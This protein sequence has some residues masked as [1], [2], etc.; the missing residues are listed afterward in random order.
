MRPIKFRAWDKEEK[1]Y[2]EPDYRGYLGII[3]DLN[4]SLGGDLL[5]RE[6]KDGVSRSVHESLFPNR[7]I[8]EQFT[9]LLDKNGKEIYEGDILRY[10]SH[11]IIDAME[12]KPLSERIS[13][14]T[15]NEDKYAWYVGTFQPDKETD[16]GKFEVIGNI[17]ENPEL[18]EA[19]K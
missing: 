7:Y 14:V 12:G 5:I 1:K 8:L 13:A 4:V 16:D 11:S 10:F 3:H 15:W 9:G 2:Y 17:H 19:K 18:L 6:E